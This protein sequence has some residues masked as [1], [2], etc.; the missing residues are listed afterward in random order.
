MVRCFR[1][2]CAEVG[3]AMSESPGE[4]EGEHEPRDRAGFVSEDAGEWRARERQSASEQQQQ[5]RCHGTEGEGQRPHEHRRTEQI[6]ASGPDGRH[7][8]GGGVAHRLTGRM[9]PE[10][11]ALKG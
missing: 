4:E 2:G 3:E 10:G 9:R 5:D 11:P 6:E 8:G 7:R 1:S